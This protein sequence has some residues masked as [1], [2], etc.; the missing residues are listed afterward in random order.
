MTQRPQWKDCRIA[1]CKYMHY[2]R[3]VSLFCSP[4]LQIYSWVCLPQQCPAIPSYL[5]VWS[6]NSRRPASLA[7]FSWH[8]RRR[9]SRLP[10]ALRRRSAACRLLKLSV[11][12]P[13][14]VW[15]SV[16]YECCTRTGV[17]DGTIPHPG[18]SYRGCACVSF[19]T[20]RCINKDSNKKIMT[21][22]R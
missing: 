9:P 7:Y 3:Y 12:H 2:I 19:S 16:S 5:A 22:G 17:C 18:E 10:P 13:T 14:G 20:Y 4:A 1:K 21:E 15:L 11:R 8:Y 6:F